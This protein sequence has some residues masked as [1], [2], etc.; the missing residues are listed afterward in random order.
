VRFNLHAR[1]LCGLTLAIILSAPSLPALA[2]Q[3]VTITKATN[4]F[5][6][7]TPPGPTLIVGDPVEWTYEVVAT[8]GR[9]LFN[10]AVTDDQGVTV[11]CPDTTLGA[12]LS[13]VCTATGTVAAGQYANIGTV[14]AEFFDSTPVADSNPSHY[15]GVDEIVITLEK[16]TEGFDADTPP[17]P[18]LPVD[19]FVDWEYAVENV[20][21]ETLINIVVSDD[22]GV[23]VTCPGT[24]LLP[25]ESM[26]CTASGTVTPGQYMNLGIVMAELPDTTTVSATDPSH[27]FGQ[28]LLLEKATNGEDADFPPGPTIFPGDPVTWT[29]EVSNPGPETVTNLDV[30]DD[31]GEIVSCP[32][33]SLE[34]GE[35]TVCTADGI[36]QAG[37]YAN[38]GTATAELPLG[39]VVSASDPS[40]YLGQG[41][42]LVKR[43][44][45]VDADDPPGPALPVGSTV[46]WTYEVINAFPDDLSNIV[47]TDSE[48]ETVTCPDTVLPAGESMT[49]TA[50]GTATAGQYMNLGTVTAEL[51]DS[52]VVDADDPS[53]YFGQELLIEKA[54][55]GENADV[56]PGPTI[57]PGDAVAWTYEVTNPGP[58]TISNLAVTDDQGEIV[59]CP[60][61]TLAD[62]ESTVCTASG[63]AAAGQYANIGT[64]TAEL[65]LGGMVSASDPSHYRGGSLD[66]EK[67]T[68]GFAADAP[69]GPVLAVGQSVSWTYEIINTFTED[70]FDIV[71]TDSEGVAVSCPQN[72]LAA[73]QSMTCTATGTVVAGQYMNTGSVTAELADG[74]MLAATNPSHYFGQHLLLEKATNGENADSPPG[75]VIAP[76]D[77]VNWTYEVTNP[78]PETITNL[79]VTDDQ[80]EVVTCPVATLASGEST[81]CT[82]SG[83]AVAGQYANI[84]T[85]TADLPL[86]GVVTASDPSHYL[87]GTLNLEK[88]TNGID[89]DTAPGPALPVGD[90]VEWTYEVTNGFTEPLSGIEVT[91]DQGETVTCPATTLAA[92]ES[93]T[94][95]AS[96]TVAL[97]QYANIGTVTAEL[98]DGTVLTADDPSHHVGQEL[99][100][101]KAT[102]GENADSPPGPV[103]APGDPVNW[104]YE[105]TNPGPE[106]V[107]SL[108]VTDDQGEVVTCPVNTLAAG[109]STVCTASNVATTG[110]YANIGTATAE[111]PLGGAVTAS[112]PSHYIGLELLLE[113]A[114][115][116]ENADVPPGPVITP[117]DPV[118]WTYEVT[119][120][121][122]V[123]VSNLEVTDDQGEIVTCPVTTLAAGESTVCTA[124][125]VAV[126]GQYANIGTATAESP[127]GDLLTATDPSHYFG[128]N[129]D[130]QAQADGDDSDSPPGQ[131]L[132]VGATVE[133]TYEITNGLPDP[134]TNI[135]VV[136]SEGLTVSCP[137]T[138]LAPG[139]SM[140]CTASTTVTPGQSM[141]IGTISAELPDGTVITVTNATHY[142][143]QH[144]TLLKATNGEDAAQPPG[145]SIEP[146]EPVTWTYQV[147]NP[148]PEA[149]SDLDVIDDQG[150]VVTCPVTTLAAGESTTC[151]ADGIA[152]LGQYTNLGT[153]TATL[154]LGGEVSAEDRSHYTG[155]EILDI[156]TMR[157]WGLFLIFLLLLGF[158]WRQLRP[159]QRID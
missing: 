82:A 52:S 9:D 116:G 28:L 25:G 136:D 131:V 147:T 87:S 78:G 64:A 159:E 7:D 70:L 50:S 140:V 37:Q 38:I 77:P 19:S 74:T 12:G 11:T 21:T 132:P 101:E 145:P 129:L 130:F 48:G 42:G 99:L 51:P 13:M 133:L 4:G 119:N 33:N 124:S 123:T 73:S 46:N 55:N 2:Q 98:P 115:N 100:L 68:N 75:P 40:H 155:Q 158:A 85:A 18:V 139:E 23:T 79:A 137:S 126:T 148:G 92:G 157:L 86:G 76:G 66:I 62:G 24:T 102:N 30:T 47:V 61:T 27:H 112:D 108:A 57:A 114:T 41:I 150:E 94:C 72:T 67:S 88:H 113:K 6:A 49:C 65:P 143:G 8:G 97:G 36:A 56:P 84:G 80:G 122:P 22:Q 118:N 127:S 14:E 125:G 128:G 138:T 83:I 10:I 151:T 152:Q 54:T 60:V 59:T 105:V 1:I 5:E 90:P 120:P 110:Q 93:M 144:L 106:T 58:A 96:G 63:V 121:G 39:G 104:T 146:G 154:P 91:D 95:T 89:A 134:L 71:V 35:S 135:E 109:E 156:P 3:D 16:T 153:A 15:F 26:T 34:A 142:F 43:T 117:G 29:Y 53:H 20:G 141:H 45:G 69:P 17:G 107:T 111:L 81:V 149:V 103:I 31:Q 32:V 44:N